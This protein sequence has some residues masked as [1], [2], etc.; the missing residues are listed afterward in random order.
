MKA[1][2]YEKDTVLIKEGIFKVW[3]D[4]VVYEGELY[5]G[6]NKMTYYLSSKKDLALSKWQKETVNFENA[7]NLAV[8]TLLDLDI[9]YL[10]KNGKWKQTDK[11]SKTKGSI[12]LE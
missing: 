10:D 2:R 12:K 3:V 4:V 11:Y 1:I 8:D 7:T 9:I 6:W 5:Y